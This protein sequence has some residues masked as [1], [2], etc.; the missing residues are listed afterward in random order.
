MSH[1]RRVASS[2]HRRR[3][4]V[5]PSSRRRAVVAA[6]SSPHR[7]CASSLL[8]C[9]REVSTLVST[10]VSTLVSTKVS[11]NVSTR[12]ST[13]ARPY[14]HQNP[15]P[16]A[17]TSLVVAQSCHRVIP[18]RLC[19]HR[20]PRRYPKRDPHAILTAPILTPWPSPSCAL[21]VVVQSCHPSPLSS[22][23]SSLQSS[24]PKPSPP[25]LV[26][27][28]SCHAV[29]AHPHQNITAILPAVLVVAQ[30]CD[31]LSSPPSSPLSSTPRPS[32]PVLVVVS[33]VPAATLTPRSPAPPPQTR[34][35]GQTV[36]TW[37]AAARPGAAAIVKAGHCS[38]GC[39]VFGGCS[40]CE[41]TWQ[42]WAGRSGPRPPSSLP[43]LRTQAWTFAMMPELPPPGFRACRWGGAPRLPGFRVWF[44]VSQ[45]LR[46][47][48]SAEPESNK[49]SLKQPWEA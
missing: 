34:D 19:P 22:P 39:K 46:V 3:R 8:P 38:E 14:P 17:P 30:S 2:S 6:S 15:Y 41:G 13:K 40:D 11:T 35:G 33:S 27:A 48:C 26:G 25:V 45:E 36:R 31:P 44:K 37:V 23:L 16:P 47:V 18:P 10:K 4:V 20:Y 21:L 43:S 49:N 1:R 7:R 28:L 24:P 12:V 29:P 32:P 9:R 42:R 5:A